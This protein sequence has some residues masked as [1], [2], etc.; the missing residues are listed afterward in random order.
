MF[1]LPG[2]RV[3]KESLDIHDYLVKHP[4]STFFMKLE[5]AGPEE[6]GLQVGDVIAVDRS[7]AAEAKDVVVA[8]IEGELV[9]TRFSEQEM[10]VW[11][12]VIGLV[13]RL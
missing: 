1:S 10:E 6:S 3:N 9:V 2:E 8:V 4:D 13:R 7:L 12:K 11:G 5:E